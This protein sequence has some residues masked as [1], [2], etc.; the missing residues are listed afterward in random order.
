MLFKRKI[1][2][3]YLANEYLNSSDHLVIFSFLV[4]AFQIKAFYMADYS[5][6]IHGKITNRSDTFTFLLFFVT[7]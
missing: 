2:V 1:P 4:L 7:G 6:S 3:N 5:I